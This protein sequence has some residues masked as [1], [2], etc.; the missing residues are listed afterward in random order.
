MWGLPTPGSGNWES[1]TVCKSHHITAPMWKSL[2]LSATLWRSSRAWFTVFSKSRA[3]LMASWPHP[4]C[5]TPP[6]GL[7]PQDESELRFS[8]PLLLD[9]EPQTTTGGLRTHKSPLAQLVERSPT[10]Q[11][12]GSNPTQGSSSLFIG[13]KELSWV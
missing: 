11:I 4:H 10:L 7:G 8:V 9:A 12:M 13:K 5:S 3:A 6:P 1:Q 2:C